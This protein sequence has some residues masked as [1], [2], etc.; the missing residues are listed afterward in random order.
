M[1]DNGQGVEC[2]Y[3][4]A[5]GWYEKSA[6]G[7]FA[8]AQFALGMIVHC[9]LNGCRRD[10]RRGLELL[11][12]AADQGHALA[13]VNLA[14]AYYNGEGVGK[15][16]VMVYVWSSLAASLGNSQGGHFRDKSAPRLSK[17]QASRA[18]ELIRQWRA[19]HPKVM[20]GGGVASG[21]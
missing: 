19:A 8:P 7:G 20:A 18:K 4:K 21:F 12:L 2:D 14:V 10:T 17:A 11:S 9:G 6:R 15:D 1:Y 5:F 13:M 3:A 16:M